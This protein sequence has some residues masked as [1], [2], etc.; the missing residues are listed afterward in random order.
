M[1]F[2]IFVMFMPIICINVNYEHILLTNVQLNFRYN[3][4][5]HNSIKDK[6]NFKFLSYFEDVSHPKY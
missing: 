6:R 1:K 5:V 2:V 3:G 4:Q